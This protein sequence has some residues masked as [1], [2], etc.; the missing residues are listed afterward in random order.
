M[1]SARSKAGRN[2]AP[3]C[4]DCLVKAAQSLHTA[5]ASHLLSKGDLTGEDAVGR[6]S[7][8]VWAGKYKIELGEVHHSKSRFRAWGVERL[9]QKT[10]EKIEPF[11]SGL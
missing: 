9:C 1:S 10:G 11:L 2:T 5:A 3:R 8:E 7:A 4:H 6:R